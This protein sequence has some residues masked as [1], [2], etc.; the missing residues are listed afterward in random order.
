MTPRIVISTIIDTSDFE[1]RLKAL[2]DVSA[3]QREGRHAYTA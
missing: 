3:A 1:R 2:E